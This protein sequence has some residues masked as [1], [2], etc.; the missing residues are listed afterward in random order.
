MSVRTSKGSSQ[1]TLPLAAKRGAGTN[2]GRRPKSDGRAN[3]KH[4]VR[5]IAKRCPMH[6]VIRLGSKIPSLRCAPGWNAVRGALATQ[7]RRSTF[8]SVIY[9]CSVRICIC[10]SKP[11]TSKRYRAAWVDFRSRWCGE[12][13]RGW[14]RVEKYLQT[15]T[16]Q[17]RCEVLRKFATC[18]RTF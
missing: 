1:L 2:G 14:E 9:R 15:D 3:V 5:V 4:H 7:L 10:W 12:F 18:F 16:S 13:T 11:I 8:G 6:V 17:R